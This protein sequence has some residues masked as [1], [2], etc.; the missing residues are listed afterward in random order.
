LPLCQHT[1]EAL[2]QK[3]KKDGSILPLE[4]EL[5]FVSFVLVLI[6]SILMFVREAFTAPLQQL[7]VNILMSE[8]VTAADWRYRIRAVDE[9]A[10]HLNGLGMKVTC[11]SIS[12]CL[13]F[14]SRSLL[15]DSL[16]FVLLFCVRVCMRSPACAHGRCSCS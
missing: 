11:G 12:W 5:P 3:I 6:L 8:R 7:F 4:S 16:F 15:L 13:L 14:Q 10:R 2:A 1:T 9:Q